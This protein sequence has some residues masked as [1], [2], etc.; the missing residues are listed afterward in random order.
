M[1]ALLLPAAAAA[2][3]VTLTWTAPGDDGNVGR[4]ASYE[5]RYSDQSISGQDTLGWWN[6]VATSAGAIPAPQAAGGRESFTVT[7]LTTGT[8]Y[9]FVLR[10]S[11]EVPNVSGFSNVRSRQVGATAL[12]T[13][14]GFTAQMSAGGVLL[15]WQEPSS[16]AGE[17]Y[18]LYRRQGSSSPDTLLHTAALGVTSWTDATAVAG[19]DYEYRLATYLGAL[20]GT[21]AVA[22][23]GVPTTALAGEPAVITGY[24]NPARTNVTLR[25]RADGKDGGPGHARIIIYDMSGHRIAHLLDDEVPAGE[26]SIQWSCSSDRGSPVAPGVYNVILDAPQ[27]RSIVRV[28]VVP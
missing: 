19:L 9:T 27:G 11:D 12:A 28:A 8:T 13:P 5:I 17:G 22:S 14:A 7:G 16:G 18:H 26:Q 10:T 15:S 21:P 1:A 24:P 6:S 2:D 25:F 20:E 23:I 4:A 3:S